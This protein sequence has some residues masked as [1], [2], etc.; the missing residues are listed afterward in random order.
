M[1]SAWKWRVLRRLGEV[2]VTVALFGIV[3]VL[4]ALGSVLAAPVIPDWAQERFGGSSV[5]TILEILASSMLAVTTFS[6]SI[7]VTAFGSAASGATPRAIGLLQR[8]PTTQRVL[9]IFIG[10]FVY[11]L[12]G[13]IAMESGYYGPAGRVVLFA[14]SVAVVAVVIVALI[15]WV[16]H[17]TRFG[18]LADT[19]GRV[20]AAALSALR[21]RS[22][23]PHLGGAPWVEPPVGA[24]PVC[25]PRTGHVQHVDLGALQGVAARGG[26]R[27]WVEADPGAFVH[28]GSVLA[29][30]DGLP[31]D[32]GTRRALE[33]EIVGAFSIAHG[34]SYD[35]DPRFGLIA[36]A[37]IAQRAL[38]PAVNDPGTALDILSR[39]AR[40]LADWRP[41]I[42]AAGGAEAPRFAAV[43]LRAL[44]P[45]D[46]LRDAFDA[47]ARDGAGVIEVMV[48]L[49]QVL[50]A[51]AGIAPG[52][53]AGPAAVRAARAARLA[54]QALVLEE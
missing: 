11:A 27:L 7:M 41:A 8:D 45:E 25:G 32:A 35:Q 33:A 34:R 24:W 38:S 14:V 54:E 1:I 36:L 5:Q 19:I 20:E 47:V 50:A 16:Q 48:R 12:V 39:L 51:L 13:I 10:A 37:E 26:F 17:L 31:G 23:R 42:P 46:L 29:R 2:G 30:C 6:V 40:A 53:F 22:E 52:H 15:R 44:A 28:P 9:A 18:L 3:A 4:A 21:A 43:H 49:Q